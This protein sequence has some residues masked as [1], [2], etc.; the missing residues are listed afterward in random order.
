MPSDLR[1]DA[2]YRYGDLTRFLH[3]L[4]EEHPQLVRVESIGHSHEG[5]DIWLATIT[6]ARTGP[7]TARGG[8]DGRPP[9]GGVGGPDGIYYSR[10]RHDQAHRQARARRRGAH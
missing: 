2:Y 5:R 9:E 10:R 8:R 1:F 4:A 6:N 7:D 3:A